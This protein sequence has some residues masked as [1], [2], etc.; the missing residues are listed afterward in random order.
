M[1]V[2]VWLVFLL[3]V[4]PLLHREQRQSCDDCFS[5]KRLHWCCWRKGLRWRL[6]LSLGFEDDDVK[7]KWWSLVCVALD[8]SVPSNFEAMNETHPI[9]KCSFREGGE[10]ICLS[11]CVCVCVWFTCSQ[12]SW[13]GT[14]WL[15]RSCP[16]T[17]CIFYLNVALR[18]TNVWKLHDRWLDFFLHGKYH[19]MRLCMMRWWTVVILFRKYSS[20][21]SLSLNYWVMF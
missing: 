5:S 13:R 8:S 4:N 15:S 12:N 6:S 10:K 7:M 16:S 18:L 17:S 21:K 19:S 20:N 14:V 9:A 3:F 11:M 1:T 2:W